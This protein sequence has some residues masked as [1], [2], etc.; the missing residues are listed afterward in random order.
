MAGARR[1]RLARP[2]PASWP[3]RVRLLAAGLAWL[4]ALWARARRPETA[5]GAVAARASTLPD[6]LPPALAGALA[7]ADGR[8]NATQALGTLFDLAAAGS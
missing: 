1:L 3:G 2:C 5:V 4:W 8:P 7:A 6:D